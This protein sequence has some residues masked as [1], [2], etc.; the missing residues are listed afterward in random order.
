MSPE[1]QQQPSSGQGTFQNHLGGEKKE[2]TRIKSSFVWK[3]PFENNIIG[4]VLRFF[5]FLMW[6]IL[7]VFI[8]LVTVLLR[9][10]VLVF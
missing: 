1:S 6:T 4:F 5:F 3:Q 7:K 9:F 2:N 10:N 8:E